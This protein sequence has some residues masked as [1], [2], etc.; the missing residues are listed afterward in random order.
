[1]S[2][3]T[4][5]RV[6]LTLSVL[7]LSLEGASRWLFGN[8]A[9]SEL[10]MRVDDPNLCMV[11]RPNQALTYTGWYRKVPP[12]QME[13]DEFGSRGFKK[14]VQNQDDK[15]NVFM[16][17]DSFTYGQ[18]VNLAAALPA[19]VNER[20][21]DRYRIWNF[22][23][24]GRN[25]Y[26]MPA[27]VERLSRMN[28]DLILVNLF[29]NDFHEPPG[30]CML[31]TSTDWQL[32][33]MRFCHLCRWTML[34]SMPESPVL[35]QTDIERETVDTIQQLERMSQELSIPIVF[36][37]LMDH[38][39]YRDFSPELPPVYQVVGQ[40]ASDYIDLEG[41]WSTLLIQEEQYQI[42]GEF[43]WNVAGNQL[44]ADSYAKALQERIPTLLP[45]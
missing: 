43:H 24:P 22:G 42:P 32:P 3:F 26:Q 19:Q 5:Q 40:Y 10:V 15:Y 9:Q 21:G 36:V 30:Q 34:A 28:P 44:L 31:N 17:G 29:I 37:L 7:L 4:R 27:E 20:M 13:S 23:V 18:G 39:A 38:H 6:L 35:S 45:N 11:L 8:Y 33:L 2:T 1:M 12:T 25:F 41:V 14:S 16:L